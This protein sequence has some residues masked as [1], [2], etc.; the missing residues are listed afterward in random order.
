MSTIAALPFPQPML[1]MLPLGLGWHNYSF[2]GET[3]QRH[4]LFLVVIKRSVKIQRLLEDGTH[5]VV[6]GGHLNRGTP[7]GTGQKMKGSNR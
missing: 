5:F 7:V 4:A 3:F 2:E 6:P 1:L